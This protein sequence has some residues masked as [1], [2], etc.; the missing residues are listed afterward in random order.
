MKQS[1]LAIFNNYGITEEE[2]NS[3]IIDI[4]LRINDAYLNN[5]GEFYNIN[6]T[7]KLDLES[8]YNMNK[9]KA[10]YKITD[11]LFNGN[12]EYYFTELGR[13]S[14]SD[15]I[16]SDPYV[17]IIKNYKNIIKDLNKLRKLKNNV[18]RF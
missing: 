11:C 6:K 3:S 15:K 13:I 1:E 18:K 17:K 8:L 2:V 10:F 5:T 7:L 9:E 12:T 16:G 4:K 14:W